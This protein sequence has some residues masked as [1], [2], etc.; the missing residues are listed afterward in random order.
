MLSQKL[1]H[2]LLIVLFRLTRTAVFHGINSA[3]Q[4]HHV[5]ILGCY[6][7]RAHLWEES[8]SHSAASLYMQIGV[9]LKRG[10]S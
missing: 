2:D 5:N 8:A 10:Q 1:L 4:D 7:T 6:R 3:M 9:H